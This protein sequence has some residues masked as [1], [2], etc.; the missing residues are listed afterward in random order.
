MVRRRDG[1]WFPGCGLVGDAGATPA[2]EDG[3]GSGSTAAVVLDLVVFVIEQQRWE[4]IER[5][6]LDIWVF[7]T[8]RRREDGVV[9]SSSNYGHGIEGWVEEKSG[10]VCILKL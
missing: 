1:G 5:T 8:D 9:R 7:R 2:M 4:W 10:G 6:G 3:L